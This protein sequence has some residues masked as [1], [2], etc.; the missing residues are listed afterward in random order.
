LR[1]VVLFS[2]DRGRIVI[3][4]MKVSGCALMRFM[5][6]KKQSILLLTPSDQSRM[7]RDVR[8]RREV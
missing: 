3:H 4:R 7:I 5:Q 6:I 1:I 8:R 2:D